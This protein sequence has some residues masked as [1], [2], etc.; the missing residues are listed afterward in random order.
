MWLE[1]F[2]SAASLFVLLLL[3]YCGLGHRPRT[4][5]QDVGASLH[6]TGHAKNASESTRWLNEIAQW[7]AVSM[8][9]GSID[10]EV[11]RDRATYM[12]TRAVQKFSG[13]TPA[14]A[15]VSRGDD[16]AQVL[17]RPRVN[18]IQVSPGVGLDKASIAL[19]QVGAIT[20][21]EM[22]TGA[23][24]CRVPIV[25]EDRQLSVDFSAVSPVLF[26]L[27]SLSIPADVIVAKWHTHVRQLTFRCDLVV[28]MHPCG[29]MIDLSFDSKPEFDAVFDIRFGLRGHGGR[30][31]S[32]IVMLA[33]GRSLAKMVQ[34]NA[35]RLRL[36]AEAP[37]FGW[38]R[39]VLP[40]GRP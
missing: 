36:S 4:K 33:I 17:S 38:E 22:E 29:T 26:G 6:E 27:G 5:S 10:E 40:A 3:L 21:T 23:T 31:A 18:R 9:G 14:P 30:K 16:A 7:L 8:C 2:L 24:Q 11:V 28:T 37:H 25:Y 32:E 35:L 19:P 13:S 39:V 15:G 12:A 1:L 20:T 34:P